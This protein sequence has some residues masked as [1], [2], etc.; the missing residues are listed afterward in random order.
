MWCTIH[1]A[2]I[3]AILF[4]MFSIFP[5]HQ[6]FYN[7]FIVK[8]WPFKHKS[9]PTLTLSSSFILSKLLQEFFKNERILFIFHTFFLLTSIL[10]LQLSLS[11][12]LSL[13]ERKKKISSPSSTPLSL[14]LSLNSNL[15]VDGW[16]SSDSD[17]AMEG[18]RSNGGVWVDLHWPWIVEGVVGWAGWSDRWCF[19]RHWERQKTSCLD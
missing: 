3:Q 15:V 18:W 10:P 1:V 8:F 14:S 19:C 4:T 5:T 9:H 7:I 17:L 11:L 2:K 13:H 6:M 16:R 12:S